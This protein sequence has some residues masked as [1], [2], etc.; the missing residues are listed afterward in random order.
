ML[1]KA[2]LNIS[3]FP[4]LLS[5]SWS[6][7]FWSLI[8]HKHSIFFSSLSNFQDKEFFHLFPPSQPLTSFLAFI[9]ESRDLSLKAHCWHAQPVAESCR[10]AWR[11]IL[12]RHLCPRNQTKTCPLFLML[13]THCMIGWSWVRMCIAKGTLSSF[14]FVDWMGFNWGREQFF[15]FSL[16]LARPFDFPCIQPMFL[17]V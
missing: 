16:V 2:P 10:V 12:H 8:I 17:D 15:A 6:S 7:T 4:T 9:S 14:E 11:P 3:K 1:S 5:T 13:L